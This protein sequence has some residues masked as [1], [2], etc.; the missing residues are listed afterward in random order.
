MATKGVPST[1][2]VKIQ[3]ACEYQALKECLIKNNWKK[4]HCEKEWK[5]F[6]NLCQNNKRYIINCNI[7][8]I[9]YIILIGWL[10]KVYLIY[11]SHN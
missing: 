4:E 8:T 7:V 2:I 6:Q 11:L 9:I 3:S 1:D 10:K 5:E